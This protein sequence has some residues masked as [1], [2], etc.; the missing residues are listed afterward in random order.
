MNNNNLN[1]DQF[2]EMNNHFNEQLTI[3]MAALREQHR[4][5]LEQVQQTIAQQALA[6]QILQAQQPA[7]EPPNDVPRV[8][9]S[10][11]CDF[12][13]IGTFNDA[14]KKLVFQEWR[15][16]IEDYL[17][18]FPEISSR[19][20]IL[21][22]SQR[23]EGAAKTWYQSQVRGLGVVFRNHTQLLDSLEIFTN[24]GKLPTRDRDLLAIL[25]Q[26]SSVTDLIQRLSNITARLTITDEEAQD[27]FR[28][29]L[30]KEIRSKVDSTSLTWNSVAD[31][32]SEALKQE[33]V[34]NYQRTTNSD[35]AQDWGERD[36]C[37]RNCQKTFQKTNGWREKFSNEK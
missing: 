2:R 7:L 18:S 29:A 4:V 32:Q 16:S 37:G 15:F 3:Q 19:E 20:A 27:R 1:P 22:V 13:L 34:N 24:A 5:Q 28:R 21:F 23:L 36:I 10:F 31:L 14:D 17:Q 33:G 11:R 26:T 9:S 35:F 25:K 6:L 8:R 12:K 30:K